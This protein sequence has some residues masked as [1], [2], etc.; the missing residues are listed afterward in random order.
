M[1]QWQRK[2]IEEIKRQT[3]DFVQRRNQ[4]VP[5]SFVE[6]CEKWLSLKLTDYQQ[7]AAKLFETNASVALRWCRQSG[8]THLISAWLLWYALRNKGSQIAIVGPSWRQTKIPIRKINGFLP[9]LPRKFYRKPQATMV[10]LRNGSLIQA[11][12]C[13]PETIRGFTLNCVYA[14][15]Y[16]YIPNDQELYDAIIFTL[17]TTDGKF[18]CSSTPGSTD[19]MFWR[20]FNRPQYNHF[21]KNHVIWEQA[22]EPEGP[23]KQ[24]KVD[25]LKEE[26][27]DDPYRWEREMMANWSEDEAVWLPL[28]LITKC[29]DTAIELWDPETVHQGRFYAGLDFGKEKDYSAFAVIE[30]L[31][32]KCVLR[33]IK[34]W[35]LDTKYATVIGY[36]KTLTDRWHSIEKIRADITGVGNYI[37]EDM[38]NGDIENVEGVNFT[39]PR[40][41]EIASLLKQRMLN[42][43]FTYPYTDIHVSPTKK[44]NFSVE[45]NVERFELR[46]DGTYRFFHP[47][48]QHDDVFWAVGLALFATVELTPE[49]YVAIL[50]GR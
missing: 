3:E 48:N 50:P 16:N 39:H 6:F 38:K 11:F 24:R 22:L 43:A 13:S 37:V 18:I 9:K 27:A 19:S 44:L 4:E 31:K 8:K 15:E 26:Y 20:F 41:Q 33:H 42:N 5:D 2:K 17:A 30:Q 40:K 23:L 47:E 35:P 25:Q 12:P 49:P 32:A 34:V 10:S 7:A 36:V 21:A 29:Q 46:K 28:A 45:L 14:D 1:K